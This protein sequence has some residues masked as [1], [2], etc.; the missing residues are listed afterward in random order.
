M[1]NENPNNKYRSENGDKE[2][3]ADMMLRRSKY[4]HNGS[5]KRASKYVEENI[6]LRTDDVKKK[7]RDVII[8]RQNIE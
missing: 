5:I 6:I 7:A 4:I 1:K 8:L 2:S 3:K